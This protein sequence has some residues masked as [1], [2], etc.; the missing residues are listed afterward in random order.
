MICR[1]WTSWGNIF[2]SLPLPS[3][4]FPSLLLPS[5]PFPSI[6][7]VILCSCSLFFLPAPPLLPFLYTFCI[8]YSCRLGIKSSAQLIHKEGT[9]GKMLDPDSVHHIIPH[10]QELMTQLKDSLNDMTQGTGKERAI[11]KGREK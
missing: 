8:C 6:R 3:P 4:P 5:P 7:L 11:T 2:P 1:Y 10:A 9:E